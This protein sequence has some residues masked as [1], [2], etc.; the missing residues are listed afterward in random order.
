MPDFEIESKGKIS[1]KFL[2]YGI[3]TFKGATNFIQNL[4]YGRNLNK[5]DLATIFIDNCGTCS[6]KHAILKQLAV[7][8]NFDDIK[9]ILAIVKMDANNTP[10]I[11]KTLIKYKL[12]FI[13]EAHNYLKFQSTIFDFTKPDFTLAN[14]SENI[15][16]EIEILPNQITDYKVAYHKIYLEK[17]LIENPQIKFSIEKLWDIRELCILDLASI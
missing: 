17:W 13:P 14:S 6:T 3:V 11:S 4:T 10:E 7:E 9:L 2:E 5:K 16:E 15:L 1:D 12:D 8:N